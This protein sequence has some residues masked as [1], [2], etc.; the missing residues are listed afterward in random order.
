MEMFLNSQVPL[1]SPLMRDVYANYESNL[2][3]IAA[4]ARD[5]GARVIISTVATNLK[6]SAPFA[7][8]H[9]VGISPAELASWSSLV[10]QGASFE[11]D[12]AYDN[13]LAAYLAAL[14]IDDEYAELEFR[15]GRT[16]WKKGDFEGAK[17]HFQ[18]AR[19][20]DT[21]R[22]RADSTINDINRSIGKSRDG[23]ELVDADAVF[24]QN[25]MGGATGSE[26]LYEHVHLT[27]AGNYLLARSMF[28][29]I[30][31][32]LAGHPV[33]ESDVATKKD[34]DQMLALTGFD[35]NRLTNE[36]LQRLQRAPFTNQLNHREEVLRLAIEAQDPVESPQE[37][38]AEYQW[39]LGK[40]P[41]DR[42][43]HNKFGSFLYNFDR[44]A[45]I[46]QLKLA[47]PWDGFPV[48]TPDGLQVQ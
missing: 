20:L 3:D 1:H 36:M 21:L 18:R 39:A 29:A 26:L 37:S 10:Q 17:Q 5:S 14:K 42:V 23:V 48:F 38:I 24:S 9:R 45:G 32:Q 7:S 46:E 2:R 34:C 33:T 8:Q 40:S 47:Q 19:D 22:F 12:H 44:D 43:L 30:A 25:T 28:L 16:L 4:V 31:P 27:P 13:A 15:I 6:D 35:S 41:D 11:N